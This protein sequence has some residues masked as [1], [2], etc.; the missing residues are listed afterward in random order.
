MSWTLSILQPPAQMAD[1]VWIDPHSIRN[2][3]D[4]GSNILRVKL[5]CTTIGAFGGG[6]GFGV[7]GGNGVGV[8]RKG[9]N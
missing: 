3:R 1:I 6:F 2:L 8:L 5:V 7:E 4:R 9:G